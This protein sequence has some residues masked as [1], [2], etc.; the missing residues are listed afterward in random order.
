[1]LTIFNEE[2]III[3]LLFLDF[4][5]QKALDRSKTCDIPFASDEP[6]DRDDMKFIVQA[7][8]NQVKFHLN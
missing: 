5:A 2:R 6:T 4:T 1:M 7:L 8:F 3:L